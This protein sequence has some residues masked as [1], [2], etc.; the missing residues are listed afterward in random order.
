MNEVLRRSHQE[1]T[2]VMTLL[3]RLQVK[4]SRSQGR[5]FAIEQT[6]NLS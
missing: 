6:Y 1:Q 4:S 2:S 5:R 3:D